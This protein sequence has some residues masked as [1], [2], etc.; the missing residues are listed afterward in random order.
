[1]QSV[2]SRARRVFTRVTA[3]RIGPGSKARRPLSADPLGGQR[4]SHLKIDLAESDDA[5]L[6]CGDQPG[7]HR[8]ADLRLT[9]DQDR[10]DVRVV[11]IPER[12]DEHPRAAAAHLMHVVRDLRLV[13]AVDVDRQP[14]LLLREHEPVAIVVVARIPVI[15][16][17]IHTGV[18]GAFS[19]IPV[20]DDAHLPIGIL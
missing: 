9:F 15:Q 10:V 8:H 7:R 18:V 3:R 2:R 11:R 1:M 20:V 13:V 5:F 17:R 19:L 6:A 4:E 12:R 16:I 14:R